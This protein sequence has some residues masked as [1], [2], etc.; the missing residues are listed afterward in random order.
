MRL[1]VLRPPLG[2]G[3]FKHERARALVSD[4]ML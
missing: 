1:L 2:L 4:S 3:R